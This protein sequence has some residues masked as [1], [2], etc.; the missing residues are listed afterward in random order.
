[1]IGMILKLAKILKH[2]F[3]Y[4]PLYLILWG[5]LKKL[6][7]EII[8]PF[9]G[10]RNDAKPATHPQSEITGETQKQNKIVISEKLAYKVPQEI[11]GVVLNPAETSMLVDGK[12]LYIAGMNG[13]NSE[14]F[15]SYVKMDKQDGK[16]YFYSE[17]P[18][19]TRQTTAHYSKP[20]NVIVHPKQANSKKLKF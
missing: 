4:L 2:V 15:S 17:N 10:G 5:F 6:G 12:A 3:K 18:D 11:K 16:L 8:K 9:T 19:R 20:Q 13:N 14:K 7:K 1:M